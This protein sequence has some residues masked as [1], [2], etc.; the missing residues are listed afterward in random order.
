MFAILLSMAL[1]A[2][3]SASQT[4]TLA[5]PTKRCQAEP[6]HVVLTCV[7]WFY[8]P[9]GTISIDVDADG[10]GGNLNDARWLLMQRNSFRTCEVFYK[11]KDPAGSWICHNVPA[12]NYSLRNEAGTA[13]TFHQLGARW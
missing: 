11:L 8:F 1:A 6:G 3:A 7:M 2:P 13:T 9:G 5:N 4:G 10:G 12:D